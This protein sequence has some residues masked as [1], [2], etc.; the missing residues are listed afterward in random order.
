MFP[1]KEPYR[2]SPLENVISKYQ[3]KGFEVKQ[4]RTLKHGKRLHLIKI[5]RVSR[6]SRKILQSVSLL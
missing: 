6:G 4:K 5:E 1:L 2:M 3:K